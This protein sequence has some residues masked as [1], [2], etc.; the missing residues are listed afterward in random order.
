MV[1][2]DGKYGVRITEELREVSY[3]DRIQLIAVDHPVSASIYT[4]DK[5]K[6]PPFPE[7]RLFGVTKPIHPKSARDDEGNDVLPRLLKRDKKYPDAFSRTYT[8]VAS[9]HHLDLDF[10]SAAAAAKHRNFRRGSVI[11]S[12]SRRGCH[13]H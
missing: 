9:I 4:N 10:G 5:F 13:R 11:R 2:R 3:L 1:P 12:P 7:F 8:G 6:S